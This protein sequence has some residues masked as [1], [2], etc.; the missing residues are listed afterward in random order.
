M[1][2]VKDATDLTPLTKKAV[3][4]LYGEAMHNIRILKAERFPLFHEPK[5]GW[6]TH[7]Q[8]NDNRFE[9]DVQMDI[10]IADGRITRSIEL[11]RR[12]L[13]KK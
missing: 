5:E 6:V 10:Q 1:A 8:F 4:A 7:L 3:K 9:Y 2:K 11:K 13:S 12:E